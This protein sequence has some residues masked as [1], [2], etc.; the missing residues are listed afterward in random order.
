MSASVARESVTLTPASASSRAWP[1]WSMCACV[2]K[3]V[4]WA[5]STPK[6]TR[7]RMRRVSL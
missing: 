1:E 7:A 3:S 6:R 2:Q 5:G 4:A